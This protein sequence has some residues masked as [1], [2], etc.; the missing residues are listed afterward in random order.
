MGNDACAWKTKKKRKLRRY[1]V[2]DLIKSRN[3]RWTAAIPGGEVLMQVI[4][5]LYPLIFGG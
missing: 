1:P 4:I 5:S 2:S 3:A